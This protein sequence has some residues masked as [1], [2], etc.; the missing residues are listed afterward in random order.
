MNRWHATEFSYN[1]TGMPIA[2]MEHHIDNRAYLAYSIPE[3]YRHIRDINQLSALMFN[4][5]YPSAAPG[6]TVLMTTE[7][8]TAPSDPPSDSAALNHRIRGQ[9]NRIPY[10]VLTGQTDR[11]PGLTNFD[12]NDTLI[13]DT[14]ASA[15]LF[16]MII[17][18]SNWGALILLSI[19]LV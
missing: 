17:F 13:L 5:P 15:H 7:V 8:D 14:G 16:E 6:Q 9:A 3:R 2:I 1:S 19:L 18:W 11:Y 12:R 4:Q 10:L